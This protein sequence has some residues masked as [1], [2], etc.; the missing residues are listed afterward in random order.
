MKFH[1]SNP[2]Q[3][4]LCIKH[5][6]EKAKEA[7]QAGKEL[8]I[9]LREKTRS[10][11]ENALLHALITEIS[12]THKW[13]GEKQD[14]ETWKRLFVSAWARSTGKSIVILPA[15]DGKGVDIVP[16]RTSKLT[17]SECAELITYI[18]AWQAE[19]EINK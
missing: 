12:K 10:L 14:V 1:L 4:H 6:W 7:L 18:Q 19:N 9:E 2:K 3:G 8:E 15:L 16:Y 11:P 13:A 5:I 17:V